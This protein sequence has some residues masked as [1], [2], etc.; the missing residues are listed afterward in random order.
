MKNLLDATEIATVFLDN[1]L[2]IKRFTPPMGRLFKL[3]AS[4]VGRP[5]TDFA[6]TLRYDHLTRDVQ[7]V[8]DRLVSLDTNIQT[9]TGEWYAMRILPYRTIDNY[10]N[11]AIIT[12]NEITKFK[13][14]ELKLQA[15]TS[16]AESIIE[17]VRE[18]MLVLTSDLRI[19]TISQAFAEQYNLNIEEAKNQRLAELQDGAWNAPTLR[20][21]LLN[22]LTDK[23]EE[24]DEVPL[25]LKLP[26]LGTR[27][28]LV[29][30]RRLLNHG[31]QLDCLL[32]GV[33]ENAGEAKE[34][35][36]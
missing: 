16:L 24:F 32:L 28:V 26:R 10:I 22:L 2:K 30:G 15:S 6:S 20:R 4:D 25:Q 36:Q 34:R 13:E 27:N 19:L 14:L 18:P 7:Q 33:S 29:Y 3:V 12:F 17:T 31:S 5:I 8:L 9:T 23:K 11:G 1:D 21:L 35:M